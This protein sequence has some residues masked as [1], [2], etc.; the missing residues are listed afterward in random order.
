MSGIADVVPGVGALAGTNGSGFVTT[1]WPALC[2]RPF[3]RAGHRL[4]GAGRTASV[5][6]LYTTIRVPRRLHGH[7]A[8]A[9][10]GAG[11]G[12]GGV[13][14][15]LRRHSPLVIVTADPAKAITLAGM[16]AVLVGLILIGLGVAKLG[17]VADLLSQEVQVGYMNGLAIT[18]IVGQLPK[19]CGFSTDADGFVDELRAF[20]AGFDERNSTALVLGLVTLAVLLVLPRVMR[21]IPAVLVAVVGATVV[22]AVGLKV[23]TVGALPQG[24]PRPALPWTSLGDVGALLAAAIG[25]TLVS[26]TDTIA[27]STSFAARRG[28]EVDPNQEMIGIGTANLAA[29]CFQGFAVVHQWLTHR[30]GRAVRRQEPA[31]RARRRP[32]RRPVAALLQLPVRRPPADGT[33]GRRDRRPRSRWLISA[34]FGDTYRSARPRWGCR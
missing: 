29:G 8:V 31:H 26:L 19:L 17:F 28:D 13:A 18:I 12:L 33:G 6:G 30:G 23:A 32:S 22:T 3:W 24:L 10:A 21:T 1:L 20:V 15:D 11:T 9:G 5:T 25:I 16:M 14:S 34:P 27:T 2:W 4:R 7:G